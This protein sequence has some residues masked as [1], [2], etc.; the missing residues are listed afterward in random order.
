G[1]RV[2]NVTGV[3][4]CALPI[5]RRAQLGHR[6]LRELTRV[7]LWWGVLPS[8]RCF[9]VNSR[10]GGARPGPPWW[11]GGSGL[12]ALD[13]LRLIAAGHPRSEERRVGNEWRARG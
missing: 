13:F 8:G 6:F 4:T 1:I 10:G 3:Q 5:C 2:R 11:P 7:H 9:W 12:A